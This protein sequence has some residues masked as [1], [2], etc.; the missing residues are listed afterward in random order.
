MS[1]LLEHADSI[2][3][4]DEAQKAI[5]KEIEMIKKEQEERH[6]HQLKVAQRKKK[7]DAK[8]EEIKAQV[9]TEQADREKQALD[10]IIKEKEE[11]L[12]TKEG[13]LSQI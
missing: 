2:N 11:L 10:D 12:K 1:A 3:K 6:Q 4:E 8:I 5:T 7:A 9:L 13:Y